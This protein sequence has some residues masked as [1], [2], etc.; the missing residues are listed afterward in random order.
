MELKFRTLNADE[1]ECRVGQVSK[2]QNGVAKSFSLL[3]YKTARVDANI[4][5]ETVGAFNWQKKFYQVKNTM[6]CSVGIK[7][8]DTNEWCWKDDAGDESE[9]EAIKGEASDSFKR[10]GF[11]WGIGRELY[12]GPKIWINIDSENTTKA[13]YSVKDIAF[14]SKKQMTKLV[15][16]NDRTHKVVYSFGSDEKVAQTSEN[17]PKNLNQAK[18][19]ISSSNKARLDAYVL[20]LDDE[21]RKKFYEWIDKKCHTMNVELL[22]EAQGD[23]VCKSLKLI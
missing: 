11:A 7:D 10:A 18:G 12:F 15:I 21:K 16:V 5:D 14:N 4:L 17:Q 8:K 20:T 9:T 3:L 2:D 19:T 13:W 1:I 6:I 23:F 22:S